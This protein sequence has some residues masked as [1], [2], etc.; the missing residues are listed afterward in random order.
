MLNMKNSDRKQHSWQIHTRAA[1]GETQVNL[2]RLNQI[3]ILDP[4]PGIC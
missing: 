4:W 3:N 1:G 2:I